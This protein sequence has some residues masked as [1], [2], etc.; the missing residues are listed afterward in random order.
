MAGS[1]LVRAYL[2]RPGLTAQRFVADPYGRPG[3]RM[4]RT[5]DVARW[6]RDGQLEVLGRVDRQVK[7]RGHRI[8]PGEIEN[9][10]LSLAC[11]RQ[12]AVTVR[13]DGPAGRLLAAHVVP[14]P[15]H[16]LTEA[17]DPEE[18]SSLLPAYMVPATFTVLDALPLTANGKEDRDALPS[19]GPAPA[20]SGEPPTARE[21]I[22]CELFAEVL[23]IP[24]PGGNRQPFVLCPPAGWTQPGLRAGRV[25]RS[26]LGTH[27]RT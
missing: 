6:G 3:E 24:R 5:G 1:G 20:P 13:E 14:A 11:V 10:L 16:D 7:I 8:E 25:P 9:A 18:L 22:L 21:E 26:R 4:Y 27:L 15:G 19:V 12:A 2:N 23:D 17:R